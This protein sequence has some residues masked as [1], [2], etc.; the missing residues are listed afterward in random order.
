[1]SGD[2]L[3][4]IVEDDPAFARTLK[5]S[6]ERRGYTVIVASSHDELM[7]LLEEH[8]PGFA[9]VDLKLGGASGLACS[10]MPICASWC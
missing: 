10:A 6:F 1:M 7:L 4:V 2:R 8:R 9:V 5:R 3:L